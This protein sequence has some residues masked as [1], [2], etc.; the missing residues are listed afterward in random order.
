[1]ETQKPCTIDDALNCEAAI[2]LALKAIACD[3][4]ESVCWV[5]CM[6]RSNNLLSSG[7]HE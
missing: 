1:M 7:R 5:P 2:K 3:K 6:L 4:L